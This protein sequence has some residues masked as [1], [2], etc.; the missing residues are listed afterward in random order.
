[1]TIREYMEQAVRKYIRTV[2]LVDD[3]LFKPELDNA[4]KLARNPSS[5]VIGL[6]NTA[7]ESISKPDDKQMPDENS[8]EKS[9]HFMDEDSFPSTD[10]SF[11]QAVI[12]GFSRL[13]IVCGL[14]Q[15]KTTEFSRGVIPQNL[16]NLCDHSDVFILD[17]K[18]KDGQA[19]S[20][21]PELLEELFKRDESLGAPRTIRFCAIYTDQ[22]LS[23]VFAELCMTIKK[24]F[25]TKMVEEDRSIYRIRLDGLSIRLYRKINTPEI[26][27]NPIR[28]FSA[29]DLAEAIVRDFA[30]E[31][32]GIM[33]ATA[34]QGI[35]EV[36]N[37]TKRIL[38]KF[39][40]GMDPALV[41]HAGLTIKGKGIVSDIT[42]LL[43]DEISSVL[44][45]ID[46]PPDDIYSFC[47]EYVESCPDKV[48][49]KTTEQQLD[50]AFCGH[51]TSAS[52]KEYIEHIF[53]QQTL[54]PTSEGRLMDPVFKKCTNSNGDFSPNTNLL[55]LL[56]TFVE[57]Q[58]ASMSD[59]DFGTLSALF[60]QRTI[61]SKKKVLRFGTIVRKS[62]SGANQAE[63]YYLCLMPTC[64]SIRLQ[65]SLTNDSG[66]MDSVLHSFPFWK[67]EL[68][69][70]NGE[71]RT[72][73]LFVRS[74]GKYHPLCAK[75]KIRD[76]FHLVRFHSQNGVVA[77]DESD[78]IFSV[79][80]SESFEWIAELKSAHIQRIAERVS[81]EFSRVGLCESEWLRL[82]VDR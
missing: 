26:D 58:T 10:S 45:D 52:V 39:P 79:D 33:S 75:G 66:G 32:E 76:H 14:Y 69:S 53:N 42:S 7:T 17:W 82:Q 20:P 19:D 22:F 47:A 65:D 13:G 8:E 34:L 70:K 25:P 68:V 5:G 30:S 51:T 59:Y 71:H 2:L 15:P 38:D 50:S 16:T 18:L 48:F 56:K 24:R 62:A 37:N 11:A 67:L 54:M 73:G 29:S 36:R 27:G 28:F 77:F 12:D 3:Q 57:R 61:Y 72:N 60:C 1:M 41:L 63:E 35:A 4:P 31:Y 43:G 9:R 81:R 74:R 40:K 21:V 6:P 64:D 49:D 46:I 55:G 78:K 44:S 23:R 80:G